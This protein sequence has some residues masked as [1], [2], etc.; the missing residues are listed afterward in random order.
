LLQ[1]DHVSKISAFDLAT[2]SWV[3]PA[4]AAMGEQ[5]CRGAHAVCAVGNQLVAFGGSS[6]FD[7]GTQCCKTLY[8]DTLRLALDTP[9]IATAAA[10]DGQAAAATATATAKATKK[11][12]L[13]MVAEP[14]RP[15]ETPARQAKAARHNPV[16]Q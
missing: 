8:R 2:D 10:S 6:S 16:G 9:P 14:C 1:D 7:P 13:D 15:E 4:L 11:R 5:H 3:Q 12:A